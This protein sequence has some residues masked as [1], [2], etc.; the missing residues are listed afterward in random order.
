MK[1]KLPLNLVRG[2]KPQYSAAIT[3]ERGDKE[4]AL[5]IFYDE[6]PESDFYF[7]VKSI[8]ETGKIQ[9]SYKPT[10]DNKI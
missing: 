8:G 3:F 2:F 9:V 1:K 5:L 4:G 10:D 6:D 7:K